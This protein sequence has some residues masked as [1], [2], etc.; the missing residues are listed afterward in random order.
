MRGTQS[1]N[2][3]RVEALGYVGVRAKDLGDWASYG[4]NLLGL[5][6]VDKTRS[7]LPFRMDDR[8]QRIIV[9]A[10]GGQGISV[11]GWEVANAAA[12]DGLAA[13]LEAAGT[14]VGRGARALAD[15]RLVKDLIV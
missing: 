8:K 15:E 2:T 10:D 9:A 7:T 5:Q 3:M 6:R 13:R 4:P 1:R 12:L 11:F 14:K